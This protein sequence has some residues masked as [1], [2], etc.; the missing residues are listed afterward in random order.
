MKDESK[1]IDWRSTG[2]RIARRTLYREAGPDSYKCVDC[3]V[4]TKEPPKDAPKNFHELWPAERRELDYPLQA[5]HESKDY[6]N[7]SIEFINW[8]CQP[9]HKKHD[10]IT[11]KG[12]S[13]VGRKNW[14]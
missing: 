2:R 12:E 13:T 4:S 14:F 11:D 5:D 10:K 1:I 3:G 7:N 8:R 9:C 6:Q